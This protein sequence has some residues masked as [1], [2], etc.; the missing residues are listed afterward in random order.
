MHSLTLVMYLITSSDDGG[1]VVVEVV[2]LMLFVAVEV[3][4]AIILLLL[5]EVALFR[6]F[7]RVV[8]V[9]E[10]AAVLEGDGGCEQFPSTS[11]S[12][13][14]ALVEDLVLRRGRF[15]LLLLLEAVIV[16]VAVVVV[17]VLVGCW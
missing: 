4:V 16:V 15:L 14:S 1:G 8:L 2:V 12:A 9:V 7:P 5:F 13:E 11:P 10:A 3:V 6:D 17:I